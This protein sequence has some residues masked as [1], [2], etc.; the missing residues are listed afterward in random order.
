MKNSF[1]SLAGLFATTAL[2]FGLAAPAAAQSDF[3]NHTVE[4]LVPY[5]AGGGTDGLARAFADAS[6]KHMS[7]PIVVPSWQ[8][9]ARNTDL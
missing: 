1:T 8:P 7:Q 4:L 2:A 5:Q 3:P 9:R 6:R